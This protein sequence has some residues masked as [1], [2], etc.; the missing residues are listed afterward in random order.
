MK[1]RFSEMIAAAMLVLMA[2][3]AWAQESTAAITGLVTDPTGAVVTGATVTARDVDRGATVKTQTN[4]AGTYNFP[5]LPIGQY[6][7]RVEANG[8]QTAVRPAFDL[9]L[10][11]T[12]RVDIAMTLGQA[13]QSVEVTSAAPVLQT[14]TT[15]VSSLMQANTI[16]GL[17]LQTRNYNQLG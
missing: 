16:A 7:L 12:A 17:P 10:N 13:S 11:Q 1:T 4:E 2:S 9:V 8:F 14:E 6:E 3:A 5:R 15:E